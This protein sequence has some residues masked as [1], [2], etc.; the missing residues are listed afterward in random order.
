MSFDEQYWLQIFCNLNSLKTS[1]VCQSGKIRR[2]VT[3]AQTKIHLP[4]PGYRTRLSWQ[5]GSCPEAFCA[6][7]FESWPNWKPHLNTWTCN[8]NERMKIRL[9]R[10]DIIREFSSL[11]VKQNFQ[12]PY[13]SFISVFDEAAKLFH[14]SRGGGSPHHNSLDWSPSI[15]VND[16]E[17]LARK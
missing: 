4:H 16:L 10:H 12:N 2:E 3:I 1:L 8:S 15:N 9:L 6:G 5:A 11:P 14:Q 17:D 7:H 13:G